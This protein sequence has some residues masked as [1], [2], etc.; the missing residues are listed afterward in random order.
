MPVWGLCPQ[1]AQDDDPPQ[2]AIVLV[3]PLEYTAFCLL[4]RDRY[5]RYTRERVQDAWVSQKLVE[6]ALGNLATIWPAVISSS[7]PAAVAWRLLDAL[8]SSALRDR[9]AGVAQPVD[10]VHRCCHRPRRMR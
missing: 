8:I 7:R 2:Q 3:L 1:S 5:L 10:A 6:A 4:H 9:R